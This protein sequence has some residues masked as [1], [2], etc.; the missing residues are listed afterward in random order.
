MKVRNSRLFTPWWIAALSMLVIAGCGSDSNP[1][2]PTAASINQVNSINSKVPSNVF[3]AT[4]TGTEEVPSVNSA[5]TG[6]GVVVVDP[7]TR[8]MKAT[9]VTADISG[10]VAYI[11]VAPRGVAGPVELPLTESATGSGVWTVTATLTADQ[12]TQ[13]QNGNYYFNVRSAAFPDG[14]IRGQITASLPQSGTAINAGTSLTDTTSSTSGTSTTT[15]SGTNATGAAAGGSGT[16]GTTANNA[17]STVATSSA[18]PTAA[19]VRPVFYTNV[20]SGA[21]VVP[22]TSSTA[23]G[24]AITLLRPRDNTLISVIVTNGITATGASLRQATSSAIGP[25]VAALNEV[26]PTSGIWTSQVTLTTAQ[27]TALNAGNFYYEVTSSAFP[28]GEIRG[29]V[30]KT[31]GTTTV[32]TTVTSAGGTVTST[33]SGTSSAVTTTPST[34]TGTVTAPAT[35]TS[36]TTTGAVTTAPITTGTT[37]VNGSVTPSTTGSTV[38]SGTTPTTGAAT[39]T[40]TTTSAGTGSTTLTTTAM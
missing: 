36:S 2:R 19:S 22:P 24:T 8:A 9:I 17:T 23:T 7:T 31:T 40:P 20:L 39:V 29:Q 34:L 6:T 37:T 18:T 28:A 1:I 14:E 32:A 10:T 16:S 13:L 27:V 30:V 11:H 3:S 15:I 4:L 12:L 25:L 5:A 33:E 38:G 35:S 21:L 26:T